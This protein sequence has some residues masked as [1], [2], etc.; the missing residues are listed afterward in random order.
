VNFFPTKQVGLSDLS[1]CLVTDHHILSIHELEALVKSKGITHVINRKN[2]QMNLDL[3]R[4]K[5]RIEKLA[6]GLDSSFVNIDLIIQKVVAGMY[7]GIHTTVL[8]ELAAE[9]A[10]YLTIIHPHYS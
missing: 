10:A 7:E 8:D 2:E 1:V 4:I 9:T 6:F 3:V 5:E